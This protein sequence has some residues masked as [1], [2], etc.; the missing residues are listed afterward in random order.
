MDD[1]RVPNGI[2]HVLR[3]GVPWRDLPA[4]DGPHTTV[5]DRFNRWAE[6]V[7]VRV[8]DAVSAGSPASMHLIDSSTIRAHQQPSE[9]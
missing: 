4:R 3:T 7:W 1:R 8:S 9:R 5:Y 2:S 6:G